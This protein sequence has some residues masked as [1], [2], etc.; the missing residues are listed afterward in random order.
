MIVNTNASA[1]LLIRILI[2]IPRGSAVH[3]RVSIRSVVS[4]TIVDLQGSDAVVPSAAFKPYSCE[5]GNA[6]CEHGR[7]STIV[8][9]IVNSHTGIT[10]NANRRR[11]PIQIL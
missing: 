3:G 5:I 4:V 1:Q 8:G 11:P 10:V 9:P 7:M 6:R 2:W